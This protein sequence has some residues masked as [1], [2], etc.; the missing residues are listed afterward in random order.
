MK[1]FLLI[2]ASALLLAPLATAQQ[3]PDKL[4]E[5]IR[6]LDILDQEIEGLR[7]TDNPDLQGG[8]MFGL[9]E[10][11]SKVYHQGEGLSI[12]GY[13]EFLYTDRLGSEADVADMFRAIIYFGYR[14]DDN[15]VFNSE[16]EW[17]HV[18][19]TAVEFAYLDYLHSNEINFRVGHLLVP[20]GIVNEMHEPTT[21]WSPNRPQVERFI[22]PSTWHENGAG[23]FGEVEGF[24]YKVYLMNGFDDGFDLAGDGLRDGRQKGSK[25]KAVDLAYVVAIDWNGIDGLNLGGSVFMGDSAQTDAGPSDFG[26]SVYEIHGQYQNGPFQ[27]RALWA[28]AS[29]DDADKLPTPSASDDLGGWY[30]EAGWDV[31]AGN[32]DEDSLVPFL[33]YSVF[34]LQEDSAADTEVTR[35]MAGIAWQPISRVVFKAA[36]TQEEFAGIDDNILELSGGYIF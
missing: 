16:I 27:A 4:D 25:A 29:V 6:R 8:S 7:M 9:G 10:A 20:M 21:F 22:I 15:W 32:G 2:A 12:G 11:A 17:E 5:V 18:D 35:I 14:F 33:R 23:L 34:D 28:A 1:P 24:S 26:T 31:F 30:L 36:Y 19:E 13:G 3:D